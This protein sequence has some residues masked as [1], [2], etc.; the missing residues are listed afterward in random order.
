MTLL[1]VSIY[2][3]PDEWRQSLAAIDPGIELRVWPDVGHGADIIMMALDTIPG[4]LFADV[5]NLGCVQFLGHGVADALEHPDLPA[6]V[7]V[8]RLKDPAI[9]RWVTEHAV[10]YILHHRRHVAAYARQQPAALWQRRLVADA[11]ETHIGVLGLGSIGARIANTLAGFDFKVS[12]WARGP[13]AIDGVD[14][15]HGAAALP[16]LL[17]GLDYVVCVLPGTAALRGFFDAKIFAA[18]KLGAYFINVG[19]GSVV[20][21][22]AI[23]AALDEDRL[24]GAALDVFHTEPLPAESPLW[25][26]P[27]VIV[28]P[29]AAGGR[30]RS[31]IAD[32]AENY[33]RV[34]AGEALL[35]LVDAA[36]GY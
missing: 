24:S 5:P 21:D 35:N 12:G 31:S 8:A 28:T 1:L 36:R 19:R 17:A 9:I 16:A 26:H 34:D 29:H 11:P 2:E 13:H 27:K 32:V 20:D 14:C 3:Q 30:A 7:P 23:V 15:H 33:R 25:R 4:G 18:M 6:G 22:E 10:A